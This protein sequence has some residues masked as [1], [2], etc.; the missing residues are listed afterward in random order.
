MLRCLIRALVLLAVLSGPSGAGPW[1]REK[2]RGFVSLTA[3]VH[4]PDGFGYLN[5]FFGLY[6]EYG[7]TERLTLGLDVG[8]D[9]QR[10]SKALVFAR[11]PLSPAEQPLKF[12]IELGA[13]EVESYAALRPGVSA[14]RGFVLWD[15]NGWMTADA[16]A[17]LPQSRDI[18]LEGDF[19]VGLNTTARSKTILQ[20]QTGRPANGQPYIRLAPSL[21]YRTGRRLFAEI[22]MIEP[23]SGGGERG[24]KLGLWHEF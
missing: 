19:T 11:W 2:G 10:M 17:I 9:I 3:Q 16:R 1:P 5:H 23:L 13:G 22:G 4:E 21:V 12:A 6:A 7:A 8:G 20:V 24:L 15:R 14:G 18:T